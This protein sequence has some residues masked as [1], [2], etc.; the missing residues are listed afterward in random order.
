M[1]VYSWYLVWDLGALKRSHD[2]KMK[3]KHTWI[4]NLDFQ[5]NWTFKKWSLQ[6]KF[7]LIYLLRLTRKCLRDEIYSWVLVGALWKKNLRVWAS[8]ASWFFDYL[9]SLNDSCQTPF[10]MNGLELQFSKK[11]FKPIRSC[12]AFLRLESTRISYG[13]PPNSREL[14]DFSNEN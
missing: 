7:K 2:L 6:W 10:E 5:I 12:I 9:L 13:K 11:K 3:L 14:F 4:Y 8:W 1:V